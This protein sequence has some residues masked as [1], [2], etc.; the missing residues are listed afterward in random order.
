[1]RKL[2]KNNKSKYTMSKQ[3]CL[4]EAYGRWRNG[5]IRDIRAS[6]VRLRENE[7]VRENHIDKSSATKQA[8]DE[9]DEYQREETSKMI[10]ELFSE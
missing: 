6:F 9:W 2:I 1:M 3:S 8:S 5:P 10:D 7:L 4:D